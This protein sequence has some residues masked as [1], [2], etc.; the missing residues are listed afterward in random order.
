MHEC[1]AWSL[2]RHQPAI[3]NLVA[4]CMQL[5]HMFAQRPTITFPLPQLPASPLHQVH[6]HHPFHPPRNVCPGPTLYCRCQ[7]IFFAFAFPVKCPCIWEGIRAGPYPTKKIKDYIPSH[8]Q[9]LQIPILQ[10]RCRAPHHRHQ[11]KPLPLPP[12]VCCSP[13]LLPLRCNELKGNMKCIPPLGTSDDLRFAFP[14]FPC[15]FTPPLNETMHCLFASQHCMGMNVVSLVICSLSPLFQQEGAYCNRP[16]KQR[17][18][19]SRVMFPALAMGWQYNKMSY[20][21]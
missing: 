6:P 8:S 17:N 3:S 2:H 19:W 7:C 14:S 18:G 16:L 21:H 5:C 1:N 15:P 13:I 9:C 4:Q 12:N 20:L 11:R 10:P